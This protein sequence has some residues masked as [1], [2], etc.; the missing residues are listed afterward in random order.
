MSPKKSVINGNSR[1]VNKSQA[2]RET[3]KALAQTP[4]MSDSIAPE[5]ESPLSFVVKGES[6]PKT[7]K[8]ARLLVPKDA[9]ESAEN[10]LQDEVVPRNDSVSDASSQV[11][12]LAQ[13]SNSA[14]PGAAAS[15]SCQVSEK[16]SKECDDDKAA[17]WQY[18][19]GSL[20]QVG[21]AGAGILLAS[22]FLKDKDKDD[23]ANLETGLAAGPFKANGMKLQYFGTSGLLLELAW[24]EDGKLTKDVRTGLEGEVQVQKSFV[25]VDGVRVE[26]IT[27]VTVKF[28]TYTGALLAILVDDATDNLDVEYY[29]EVAG[30][31]AL[32]GVSL[33]AF[34]TI[35][36][37]ENKLAITPFTELALRKAGFGIDMLETPDEIKALLNNNTQTKALD[38]ANK[39]ITAWAG[40]DIVSV[41]PV[42]VND[43]ARTTAG[44][45]QAKDYGDLLASLSRLVPGN[46]NGGLE[47]LLDA[48][49]D[50]VVQMLDDSL[51]NFKDDN[52]DPSNP[53]TPPSVAIN[54][55]PVNALEGAQA[56][57]IEGTSTE[58]VDGS[59]VRISIFK[60]GVL[61][62]SQK[63]LVTSNEWSIQLEQTLVEMG[64]RD[65]ETLTIRA[66]IDPDHPA[67]VEMLYDATPPSAQV[68]G[69]TLSQ[70][71]GVSGTDRITNVASQTFRGSLNEALGQ[72]ETL[73]A[74]LDGG[75]RWTDITDGVRG[76]S[77]S[78]P[79]MYL[80][81]G[82]G[83]VRFQVQDAAGNK[84][85]TAQY[86]YTL[87]KTPPGT[88]SG[89]PDLL[90]ADD[91]GRSSSD[92]ITNNTH[93]RL[94]VGALPA[95]VDSVQLLVDGV[96]VD[97]TYNALDGT[98]RPVQGLGEGE[99][100]L[101]IRWVDV[102]GNPSA[103][104]PA[105]VISVDT[106][107][108]AL[109]M[110]N[111]DISADSGSSN[112][113]FA[114]RFS[115]QTVSGQLDK[116][117]GAGEKVYG[118][119]DN[120]AS[121]VD[122]TSMING[123]WQLNWTGVSLQDGQNSLQFKVVD[124]AG[125]TSPIS[126]QAYQLD[127]FAPEM[128]VSNI[129]ISTDTGISS[130]DFITK[131]ASQTVTGR[132]MDDGQPQSLDVGD[133]LW[134][135]SNGGANW[136]DITATVNGSTFS[137]ANATLASG[138]NSLQFKVIDDAGNEGG[139]SS[140]NYT[141]DTVAPAAPQN[142][143]WATYPNGINTNTNTVTG[144]IGN[145]PFTYTL[146]RSDTS[147][148]NLLATG[149][150]AGQGLFP[151]SFQVPNTT[152]IR[153]DFASIN[154]LT[155]DS[156]MSNPV[157]AF[158]SIGSPGNPVTIEFPMPVEV[159]WSSA[160]TIDAGTA[161]AATRLTGREGA[162]VVRLN[163]TVDEF[164]FN[165]LSDEA[166]VNFAFGAAI[167]DLLSAEQDTGIKS[168]DDITQV[169]RPAFHVQNKP[170][171]AVSAELLI[172]GRVV[173]ATFNAVDNTLTPNLPLSDG[174][175]QVSYRYSDI[176]GNVSVAASVTQ[177]TI[178][179]RAP[180]NISLNTFT[181]AAIGG[182]YERGTTLSLKINGVDIAAN[183]IVLDESDST[184]SLVPTL[185][186]LN[187]VSV[188]WLNKANSTFDLIATDAAG[189]VTVSSKTV[190]KDVFNAPYVKEFIPTDGGI[191]ANDTEGIATLNLV[192]S[193]S[194]L[195]GSGRIKLWDVATDTL[196]SEVDVTT[197]NVRI[198]NGS[199]VYVTLP[200]LTTGVRYYV[201]LDAGTFVDSAGQHYAGK[202]ET[203]TTG[204]D[205]V[206]AL[207]SIAPDFV[208]QDDIINISE[209]AAVV[210][211]T[212][213]VVSNAA[214]LEDIVLDNLS[215]SVSTPQGAADVI[216]TLQSY[217]NQTGEFVF[218]VPASKWANGNYGYTVN[219]Q[220]SAG[221]ATSVSADYNF[222]NL[223]VDLLA[224]TGIASSIDNIVDN[225]GQ[226]QGNLFVTSLKLL[227]SGYALPAGTTVATDVNVTDLDL[228]RLS[229]TM[230][231]AW[232]NN[233]QPSP[234]TYNSGSTVYNA[235]RTSVTFWVQGPGTQAVQ[236]QLTDT[237]GGIELK[238]V[239]AKS[240]PAGL[241]TTH[242]WNINSTGIATQPFATSSSGQG[243][244]GYGVSNLEYLQ[245][246]K[247]L[248]S[249]FAPS[250]Q[251]PS[252]AIKLT[253]INVTD[254]DL[255]KLSAIMGGAWIGDKSLMGG[256][257]ALY[258]SASTVYNSDRTSVTFWL[259]T[260]D[261]VNGTKGTLSKA[262]KVELKDSVNPNTNGIELR[263]IDAAYKPYASTD[264][265]FNWNNGDASKVQGRVTTSFIADGYGLVGLEFVGG[266]MSPA[267]L[268][269]A[270]TDDNTPTLLG[271]LTRALAQ[272]EFIAIDRTDGDDNT[273]TITGKDGLIVDGTQWTFND[274]TLT[275]GQY[276]YRAY[277][278]DAAGN[279]SAASPQRVITLELTAP[280]T[281]V[282]AATLSRDTGDSQTDRVTKTPEQ[283]ITGTLSAALVGGEK[284]MASL[285]GGIT[286][287][288][289][290]TMVTGTQFV[291]MGVTLSQGA[292]TVLW[293]VAD[294]MGNRGNRW[295][296]AFTLDTT[297]PDAPTTA[298]DLPATDDDGNSDT[299]NITSEL[300]PN[301]SVNALPD[302]SVDVELL[303]DGVL[304][305]SVYDATNQTLTPTLSLAAGSHQI[306]YRYVDLAGNSGFSSDPLVATFEVDT[307]GIVVIDPAWTVNAS[308]L[309][310]DYSASPKTDWIATDIYRS[311]DWDYSDSYRTDNDDVFAYEFSRI[312]WDDEG[313]GADFRWELKSWQIGQGDRIKGAT[314]LAEFDGN[315]QIAV[316]SS[317]GSK[318][319]GDDQIDNG[320]FEVYY[321]TLSNGVFTV[322]STEEFVNSQTSYIGG[323]AS[324][325]S[326]ATHTMILFDN[327]SQNRTTNSLNNLLGQVENA[328]YLPDGSYRETYLGHEIYLSHPYWQEAAV[329]S[330]VYHERG[331]SLSDDANGQKLGWS[332]PPDYISIG[333]LDADQS[334]F[335]AWFDT[336]EDG[337]RDAGEQQIELSHSGD[338]YAMTYSYTLSGVDFAAGHYTVRI[339]DPV[340]SQ[341]GSS[342]DMGVPV[343]PWGGYGTLEL[344][345]MVFRDDDL[346]I[347]DQFTN[348]ASWEEWVVDASSPTVTLALGASEPRVMVNLGI[349]I[350]QDN[351]IFM[352]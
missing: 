117:L 131:Q 343:N 236:L 128:L 98:L 214:V 331:W 189:N 135:S 7:T 308:N 190:T 199:D 237:T 34:T 278:E 307:S 31:M 57:S 166:Y 284:L 94:V 295:Q 176:A 264:L 89:M 219:L 279:R 323:V 273:V 4:V 267:M 209:S 158:G 305:D 18:G 282:T 229:I 318:A 272:G 329:V 286:F 92:N 29:D 345:E 146:N 53:I 19:T 43:V 79:D 95:L 191:L 235:Y 208:A 173:D 12:T 76:T 302:G 50:S 344:G 321:G 97:A 233:G 174:V 36:S 44:S 168:I 145:V 260:R 288:D 338:M 112:T 252:P 55:P 175:Y 11:W 118:S 182:T 160:V 243:Y 144:V 351:L 39:E 225:V 312:F 192:F 90:T 149:N 100:S 64:V 125:N 245:S 110:G 290:T 38:Q 114:T 153:N 147:P 52:N 259:Q 126:Q 263:V 23:T 115:A 16:S 200:G 15:D 314:L 181:P 170:A 325:L 167:F 184:W 78:I 185:A 47:K 238:I 136:Q 324:T 70:D 258:N 32:E 232:V 241:L 213:K 326:G 183:R 289:I 30:L 226:T 212:G 80:S 24:D 111:I 86:G 113:D 193:K 228:S 293:E 51:S 41:L 124:T 96:L 202:N 255:T 58:A 274:G 198:E 309:T 87:D 37:G 171:D 275:A 82:N 347:I 218:T 152:S 42:A 84:G 239:D 203:G 75:I 300:R 205:F 316:P 319:G 156:P 102:A 227:E 246:W 285:D 68:S 332:S 72:G 140:K 276:T 17:M 104:S 8:T 6:Q 330:G 88:P 342:T 123:S 268:G 60:N 69:F 335:G 196:V 151:T 161:S 85:S 103:P 250:A 270:F 322:I 337:V 74:S 65:S 352:V 164:F 257:S 291:W 186:E 107:L 222:A 154:Q 231:G 304:V 5:G 346:L 207:A 297:G 204:W 27:G 49:P 134:A 121:W 2:D 137:W 45:Q 299:D 35:N 1:G 216:A 315:Q 127:Q 242:N 108:P 120:G 333:R 201:T 119:V 109:R 277:V 148:L 211:I 221:A 269:N 327:D 224:P 99:H 180:D 165:Y 313:E 271:S 9:E 303:V 116:P 122:V 169:T 73:R 14:A 130:T 341:Q 13:A 240:G 339:V 91:S 188:G 133:R 197:P 317:F 206:G 340:M 157:L 62:L 139:V 61:L 33:R 25:E 254:L 150:M 195:A 187:A 48:N 283:T 105:L 194:V 172:N 261:D 178:D 336:N 328:S 215:V 220:G 129:S 251:S 163:G 179:T 248:E 142:F 266:N 143:S 177:V 280:T 101:S 247:L 56:I 230:G 334:A 265:N 20:L 93:P 348:A 3:L 26:V 223:G 106:E 138:G 10:L 310:I 217:N 46:L 141:L 22:H 253:D 63:T 67:E 349:P 301:F 287:V 83:Q 28:A 77:F 54:R 159:L 59:V 66:Y 311:N 40:V 155:F 249:G 71:T 298:P 350:T 296:L 234:G 262:I 132:L 244:E 162:L 294:A 281:E 81:I 292:G 21:L 320:Q 210:R 256:S 306:T